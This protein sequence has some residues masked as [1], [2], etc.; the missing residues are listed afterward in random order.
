MPGSVAVRV[1]RCYSSLKH[2][3]LTPMLRRTLIIAGLAALAAP[4]AHAADLWQVW[5]MAKANDPAFR[6]A[7]ADRNASMQAKPEAWANLFPS[8]DLS[9]NRTWNNN[10]SS[11]V[12]PYSQPTRTIDSTS[13][14]RQDQWGATL[15]QTLFNWQQ[16]QGVRGGDLTAAEAEATYESTLQNLIVTVSQAYFNVLNAQDNLNADLANERALAKQYQ[17][18]EEQ[19]KVGLV[20]ITGVKEAEAGWDQAKAQVILDRQ[21]L[22]QSEEALRA[23][24]GTYVGDLEEPRT[25]MPLQSPQPDNVQDWIQRALDQNPSLT[26]ARLNTKIAQNQVSQ[27]K[28]GY[29]PQLDL[30][31]QHMRGSTTGNASNTFN[32]QYP[33]E[34]NS[35]DNSIGLQLSWNIFN[36]GATRATVKQYQYQADSAMAQEISQH[37]SVEQQ[38]R[39]AYLGVLSG[40]AQV[41]ATRQSVAASQVSLQA[42]EAGLKVGTRT[43]LDVL[44]ARSN[45]LTA[46]KSYY[47]ARYN[48]LVSTLQLEQAAGSL[49]PQDVKRLNDLLSPSVAPGTG[50]APAPASAPAAMTSPTGA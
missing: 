41:Q 10:S 34:S 38:V 43:T 26:A 23:I 44:T 14:T 19:Y 45:L 46:Q 3:V 12:Y 24:T 11:A 35:S 50:S 27:Q 7:E 5:Q 40:I 22:A 29:M 37:R 47:N 49:S 33:D 8:I 48:Y 32:G 25:D 6:Q 28:A 18:S 42:T 17:Q 39:N 20:A 4:A 36:G 1:G 9:A 30:V 15:T 13:N 16:F 2:M 21:T 31:L